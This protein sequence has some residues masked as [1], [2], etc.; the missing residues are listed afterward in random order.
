MPATGPRRFCCDA[1][2]ATIGYDGLHADHDLK[3]FRSGRIAPTTRE[4][5]DVLVDEGIEGATVLDVGAGVGA[6]H[7]TLLERGAGAAVD[8][9]ASREYL[10]AAAAE[11]ERRGLAGR[12]E[13]R[14]GDVVELAAELPPVDVVTLDQVICCYP[15][16][17]ALVGAVVRPLPR[18]IGLTYPHDAWWMRIALRAFNLAAAI[19]R[20][21]DKYFVHRQARLDRLMADAGYRLVHEGGIPIW[22]VLVYR[23]ENA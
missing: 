22:R 16:L 9:D 10:A 19:R 13:H 2:L 6:V 4:L 3:A 17:D 8:V 20:R 18:L 14:Y 21:P 12:V 5:I 1:D 15:Y 11:A 23:R 7:L